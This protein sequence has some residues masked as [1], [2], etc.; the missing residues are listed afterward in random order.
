L[1]LSDSSGIRKLTSIHFYTNID[2][3]MFFLKK[4][5]RAWK[6]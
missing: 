5:E 3:K 4:E 1:K 2:R 6:S